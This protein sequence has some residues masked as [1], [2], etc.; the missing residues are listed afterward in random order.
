LRIEYPPGYT[1]EVKET[2]M[3][4]ANFMSRHVDRGARVIVGLV[5][6]GVGLALGGGWF[7]LTLVGLVPLAA[8]RF[9]FCLTT[10][11]L[12]QPWPATVSSGV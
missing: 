5:M 10:P 9:G 8:G 7:A 6:V 3:T 4:L 12:H 1:A 2:K 11:L